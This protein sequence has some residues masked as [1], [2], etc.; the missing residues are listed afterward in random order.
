MWNSASNWENPYFYSWSVFLHDMCLLLFVKNESTK[1]STPAE[2]DVNLMFHDINILLVLLWMF[3][4]H[5]VH[6]VGYN[7]GSNISFR[8]LVSCHNIEVSH[9]ASCAKGAQK[10]HSKSL[11]EA[12]SSGDFI[13]LYSETEGQCSGFAT[14]GLQRTYYR[15]IFSG[16]K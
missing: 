14:R 2:N 7:D 5:Y 11:H 6:D 9:S 1:T 16:C 12:V 3:S 15:N 10:Y 13:F 4:S 8:S